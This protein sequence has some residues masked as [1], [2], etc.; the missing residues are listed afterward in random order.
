MTLATALDSLL[1]RIRAASPG[2][3]IAWLEDAVV[4]LR[5]GAPPEPTL[6]HFTAAARRLGRDVLPAEPDASLPGPDDPV[7]VSV[8]TCDAAGRVALLLAVAEGSAPAV[9]SI[10][11]KAYRE[12]DTREKIAVVRA[13]PLLPGGA[14]FVPVALDAGRI[15]ETALFQA[16]ASDNP[17]P[18]RHYPEL[19]L[20]KLVLKAAFV[21]APIDRITG[22]LRR[23]NP[24]LA[25]AA[26]EYIDQQESAGRAFPPDLWLAIAPHPP[27]GAVG[28]MLGYLSHAVAAQR[29]GAAH[30]LRIVAQLRT[31]SFLEE[32]LGAE[33]DPAV[34]T[35]IERAL[36]TGGRP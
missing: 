18:A 35:A 19:E 26:M 23:A 12:G 36:A 1:E 7:P 3:S 6:A 17:F 27:P 28:R 16:L 10:V 20:N 13:L 14:R 22:L 30:G 4:A 11:W 33:R 24:E 31:A 29:G 32:R 15:N 25:R 8:L 21:G 5:R 2:A 34:K 9:E